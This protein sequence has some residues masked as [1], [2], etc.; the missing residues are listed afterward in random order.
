MNFAPITSDTPDRELL[1]RLA[2][3]DNQH[4]RFRLKTGSEV[5]N[6]WRDEGAIAILSDRCQDEDWSEA[7]AA[8]W[9]HEESGTWVV[10]ST[11]L[12]PYLT[13]NGIIPLVGSVLGEDHYNWEKMMENMALVDEGNTCPYCAV[14]AFATAT[15]RQLAVALLQTMEAPN[16]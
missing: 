6:R 1:V 4:N 7:V 16:A 12:P 3:L 8:A 14:V 2:L 9:L 5:S 11:E 13:Y 15:P 10:N